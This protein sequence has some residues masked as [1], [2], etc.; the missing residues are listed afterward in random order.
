MQKI[1]SILTPGMDR[2]VNNAYK[3]N[4]IKIIDA[5]IKKCSFLLGHFEMYQASIEKGW[6]GV[7][8]HR[9]NQMCLND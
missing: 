7:R 5:K 8:L 3:I 4:L 2:L 9:N 1:G 6:E